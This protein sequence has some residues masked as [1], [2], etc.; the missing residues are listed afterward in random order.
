MLYHV[1]MDVRLPADLDP[2]A[3]AEI[4]ARE[5]AYSQQLQKA[6]K[7]P[8]LWRIAGE[9]ANFSIL[10]VADHDELHAVLSGLPLFPFMDIEVTPLAAHPSKIGG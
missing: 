10:D 2:A 3:R 5:K 8:Q 4:V 6:G 7:W 1:R 9:Y